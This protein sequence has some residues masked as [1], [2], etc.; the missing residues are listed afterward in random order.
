MYT[1]G[2]DNEA[3]IIA[4]VNIAERKYELATKCIYIF[5]RI[6]PTRRIVQGQLSRRPIIIYYYYYYY[7]KGCSLYG[8]LFYCYNILYACV[9]VCVCVYAF[10]LHRSIIRLMTLTSIFFLIPPN[11]FSTII[12]QLRMT[13]FHVFPQERFFLSLAITLI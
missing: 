2:K 6:L 7:R 11:M 1:A 3:Q 9:C 13:S 10:V 4:N 12:F 5:M 8:C